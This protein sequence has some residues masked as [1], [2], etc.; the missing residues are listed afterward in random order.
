VNTLG[1][2]DAL[3]CSRLLAPGK[4]AG[5]LVP[6][7]TGLGEYRMSSRYPSRLYRRTVRPQLRT[8]PADI[9]SDVVGCALLAVYRM[10]HA[11][12]RPRFRTCTADVACRLSAVCCML[13]SVVAHLARWTPTDRTTPLGVEVACVGTRLQ[14][15]QRVL[16]VDHSRGRLL[17]QRIRT[18]HPLQR[19]RQHT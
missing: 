11:V 10:L 17:E 16:A 1:S 15:A 9:R 2:A 13:M 18:G 3:R 8:R 6:G 14:H 19:Q 12:W 5:V 7:A 4:G